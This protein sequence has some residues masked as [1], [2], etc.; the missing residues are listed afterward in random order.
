M[1]AWI[2]GLITGLLRILGVETAKTFFIRALILSALTV[3]LP[4][5]LYNVVTRII[6]EMV[7][8]ATSYINTISAPTWTLDFVGLGAWLLECLRLQ[9]CISM[10][11][12]AVAISF[13]LKMIK[14]K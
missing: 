10:L 3:I 1:W 13:T 14:V 2:G 5:I 12:S 4:V 9:E 8:I 7:N 6:Q 11:L